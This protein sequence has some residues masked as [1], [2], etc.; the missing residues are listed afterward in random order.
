MYVPFDPLD[1][2]V[3]RSQFLSS[4]WRPGLRD[5]RLLP[6]ITAQLRLDWNHHLPGMGGLSP[7]YP[8]PCS[9]GALGL[10]RGMGFWDDYL[11]CLSASAP[12]FLGFSS[13]QWDRRCS[14]SQ[15]ESGCCQPH[16][17]LFMLGTAA[18]HL[19]GH[20]VPALSLQSPAPIGHP[21]A[22]SPQPPAASPSQHT[23]G[24]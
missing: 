11:F 18:G 10:G 12:A 1:S 3:R 19:P 8:S 15:S 13:A 24:F 17:A 23:E 22:P 6:K 16:R 4:T 20:T 2:P 9:A 14:P 7:C 5:V 21:S